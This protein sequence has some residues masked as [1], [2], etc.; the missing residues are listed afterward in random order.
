MV[1]VKEEYSNEIK[2]KA[3]KQLMLD[4][5]KLVEEELS[6]ETNLYYHDAEYVEYLITAPAY[7]S[8]IEKVT[9]IEEYKTW[10][11]LGSKQTRKVTSDGQL[12]FRFVFDNFTA[13]KCGIYNPKLLEPITNIAKS[14]ANKFGFKQVKIER[15]YTN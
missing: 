10:F 15:R 11:G 7:Y 13:F 1:E 4:I 12:V 9:T 5:K 8:L 14:F 2:M 3:I 6:I